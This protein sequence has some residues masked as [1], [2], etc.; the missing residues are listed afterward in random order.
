MLV[1][2]YAA[3]IH[4]SQ[5]LEYPAVIGRQ[6]GWPLSGPRGAPRGHGGYRTTGS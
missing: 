2:A 3:T 4:K 6:T 5:G 1:P